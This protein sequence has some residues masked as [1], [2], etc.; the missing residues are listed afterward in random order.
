M[1]K[2]DARHAD[3]ELDW[4]HDWT[5]EIGDEEIVSSSWEVE[6]VGPTL[7]SPEF[8]GKVASVRV[9][10]GEEGVTYTFTNTIVTDSSDSNKYVVEIQQYVSGS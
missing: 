9:T 4:G 7:S 5:D 10:G 6:P 1:E 2:W 8:S 3:E